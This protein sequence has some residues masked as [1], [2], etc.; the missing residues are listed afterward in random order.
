MNDAEIEARIECL[1][2]AERISGTDKSVETLV[3][4]TNILYIG[5][6]EG[7]G[8]TVSPPKL[9]KADPAPSTT[10]FGKDKAKAP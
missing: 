5:V 1:K 7:A 9:L 10:R 4:L 6:V 3:K 8:A 2:V